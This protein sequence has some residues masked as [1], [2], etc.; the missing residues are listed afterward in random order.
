MDNDLTFRTINQDALSESI[1]EDIFIDFL[2]FISIKFPEI[3]IVNIGR[4]A[5][6]E[7]GID[8]ERIAEHEFYVRPEH[9]EVKQFNEK[10]KFQNRFWR[11]KE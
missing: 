11:N 4:R 7:L 3:D 1:K 8:I 5:A 2:A 6:E 9:E 10:W